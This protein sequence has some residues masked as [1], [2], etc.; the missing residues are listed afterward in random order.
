[1]PEINLRPCK[2]RYED[3]ADFVTM[4]ID[5]NRVIEVHR[6]YGYTDMGEAYDNKMLRFEEVEIRIMRKSN[7]DYNDNSWETE[8]TTTYNVSLRHGDKNEKND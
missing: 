2:H 7:P 1:M 6:T 3:G 8:S 5:D 4:P